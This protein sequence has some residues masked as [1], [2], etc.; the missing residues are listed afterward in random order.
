MS[1]QI[2]KRR[3]GRPPGP[4]PEEADAERYTCAHCG[5]EFRAETEPSRGA[6]RGDTVPA[7]AYTL[8]GGRPW[9][10]KCAARRF[11]RRDPDACVHE[12]D[13]WYED[14]EALRCVTSNG[15]I[16]GWEK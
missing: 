2:Q 9:C 1:A 11:V 4:E 13:E 10:K 14:S 8:L 3:R 15:R 5:R 6:L 7:L 12:G 16:R